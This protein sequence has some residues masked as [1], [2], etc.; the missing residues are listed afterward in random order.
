MLNNPVRIGQVVK[1][2]QREK[3]DGKE[4]DALSCKMPTNI[5]TFVTLAFV[6]HLQSGILKGNR[7]KYHVRQFNELME[8]I[9]ALFGPTY[10]TTT[11]E[12]E[13]EIA[14]QWT[15]DIQSNVNMLE[16]DQEQHDSE[17]SYK[18]DDRPSCHLCAKRIQND[19]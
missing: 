10:T 11:T 13:G 3:Q 2:Y 9:N 6:L 15:L 7:R 19:Y 17:N 18:H 12:G 5:N 4:N 8:D 14:R 1:E 16:E